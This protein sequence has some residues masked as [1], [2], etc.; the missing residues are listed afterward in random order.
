MGEYLPLLIVGAIIG[1]FS[2]AFLIAYFAVRKHKEELDSR[3]R[4]IA[5]GELS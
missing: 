3:E 4:N 5:D 1:A 2:L